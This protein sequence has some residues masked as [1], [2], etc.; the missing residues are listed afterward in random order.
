MFDYDITRYNTMQP[1]HEGRGN[2]NQ[3]SF[4]EV[5]LAQEW[6]VLKG[7]YFVSTWLAKLKRE[8]QSTKRS[9]MRKSKLV[10]QMMI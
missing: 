10:V 6:V 7:T 2:P 9:T 4:T 8:Y 3:E 5:A 1:P